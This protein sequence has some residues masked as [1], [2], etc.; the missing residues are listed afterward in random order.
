[1]NFFFK[2]Y[3]WV[4]FAFIKM[5]GNRKGAGDWERES[6]EITSGQNQILVGP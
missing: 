2:V 4:S 6:G 5:K 3:F 1:M